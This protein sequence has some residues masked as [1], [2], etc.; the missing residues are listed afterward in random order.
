MFNGVKCFPINEL[1]LSQ[2]Y[3]NKDKLLN[4]EKWFNPNDLSNFPPLPVYDFG[5][6]RLTLTDGHSRAFI[7][8]KYGLD[9]IPVVYDTDDIITSETGQTLYKNDIIWC[10]RY[11]LNHICDLESR[12]ISND[13]YQ[14]L[15]IGR[16]NKAYNL[17]TQTTEPQRLDLNLLH[18]ELFLYGANEKLD[19]F[20]FEDEKGNLYDFSARTEAP[21][22]LK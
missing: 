14:R 3:L 8:Y 13:E 7:A 6:G 15:W 11:G 18:P 17:L 1:G 2:I 12:I 16:C 10:E 19:I 4:I 5:N 9:K 21:S 22:V 20:F